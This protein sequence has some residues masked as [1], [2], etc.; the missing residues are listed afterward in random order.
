MNTNFDLVKA[1]EEVTPKKY[2]NKTLSRVFQAFRIELNN[3]FEN[4][5]K[6]TIDAITLLSPGGRLAIITFHSLE[7]RLV[8]NIFKTYARG[9]GSYLR[10]MGYEVSNELNKEI[11]ILTKKPIMPS[12]TEILNN[13]RARSAKLRIVERLAVA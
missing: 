12:R 1:I 10:Q 6:A 8:K 9:D 11:K 7:D 13:K 5:L 2:L 3:E 4:I